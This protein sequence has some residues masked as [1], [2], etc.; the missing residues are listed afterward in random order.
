M[1]IIQT[2]LENF[3]IRYPLERML[4][5]ARA[6]FLDIASTGYSVKNSNLYL[7]GCA[8]FAQDGWNVIQWFA[9]RPE[10]E[11]ELLKEFFAFAKKYKYIVHYNGNAI[12]LP[13][14]ELKCK[15]HELP[16]SFESFSEL[17]I[18]RHVAP[19]R[20]FLKLSD[21]N[22]NTIEKF[23]GV[24]REGELESAELAKLYQEYV[25]YPTPYAK[26]TMLLHNS[27]DLK[28]LLELLP[29]LSYYD[30]FNNQINAASV[31]VNDYK[32]WEGVKRQ[33]VLMTLELPVVVPQKISIG[34]N[35]CYFRGSGD[36]GELKI[37]IFE[38]ELKYFY[39]NYKDYYYLPAEDMAIRKSEADTVDKE[40]RKKATAATCYIRKTSKF[41]PQWNR[42]IE[43]FF[44]RE[45][46][47]TD[48]FF[49]ITDEIK[50]NR[51]FFTMYANHVLKMLFE[52]Y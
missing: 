33:E 2:T 26:Q 51:D 12:Q 5:P 17:D 36:E 42:F 47:S 27:D 4:D 9:E 23:L 52:R 30:L 6:L 15:Q 20:Y 49:E 31:R 32:D 45:Y 46:R 10:E 11:A 3:E 1:K 7:I 37:R 28:R 25:I 38:E 22:R 29:I 50:Q 34:A 44:K 19:Y 43:P 8:Y 21:C 16:Y 41:L 40:R 24:E 13:Y 48:L 35:N 39:T 14:I 18:Y